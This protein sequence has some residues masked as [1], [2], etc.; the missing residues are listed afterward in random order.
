MFFYWNT[1]KPRKTGCNWRCTMRG[2]ETKIAESLL[3]TALILRKVLSSTQKSQHDECR[4]FPRSQTE[5]VLYIQQIQGRNNSD[6]SAC[7]NLPW[8]VESWPRI[9]VAETWDGST[10]ACGPWVILATAEWTQ[11]DR[12]GAVY[13]G[14]KSRSGPQAAEVQVVCKPWHCRCC[15]SFKAGLQV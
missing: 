1:L 9:H 11:N 8:R 13:H 12:P 10:S 3:V 2:K 14:E 15:T 6:N 7:A 5:Q 4:C